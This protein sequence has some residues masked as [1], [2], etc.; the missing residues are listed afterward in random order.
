MA[1]M[2]RMAMN[3]HKKWDCT[4]IVKGIRTLIDFDI[5]A[6]HSGFKH[7]PRFMMGQSTV[8]NIINNLSKYKHDGA[9]QAAPRNKVNSVRHILEYRTRGM[10]PIITEPRV[11]QYYAFVNRL[12]YR[13][14]KR[15]RGKQKVV[16]QN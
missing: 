12:M 7:R 8:L 14:H 15:I 5:G 13:P 11:K 16:L 4:D 9:T 2:F 10:A 3:G 6:S 1:K